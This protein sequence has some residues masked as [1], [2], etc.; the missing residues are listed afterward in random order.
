MGILTGCASYKTENPYKNPSKINH[1][2]KKTVNLYNKDLTIGCSI[3]MKQLYNWAKQ[4]CPYCDVIKPPIGCE[5]KVI[6]Y[7]VLAPSLTQ[8]EN[9]CYQGLSFY[10]KKPEEIASIINNIIKRYCSF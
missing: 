4:I 6:N 3:S 7:I 1:E 10:L 2:I 8:K 9:I 5:N